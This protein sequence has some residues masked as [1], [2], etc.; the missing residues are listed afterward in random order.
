MR[1]AASLVQSVQKRHLISART[2]LSG[3]RHRSC[4]LSS[5]PTCCLVAAYPP[6][7][8]P[9]RTILDVSTAQLQHTRCQYRLAAPYPTSVPDIAAS[10]SRSRRSTLAGL[11]PIVSAQRHPT[12]AGSPAA[13]ERGP[14]TGP[15]YSRALGISTGRWIQQ[16]QLV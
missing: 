6:S 9:C 5:S 4:R 10:T 8:P 16:Y 13:P 1:K 3:G 11:L 14:P 12:W 15:W 7:V 2:S